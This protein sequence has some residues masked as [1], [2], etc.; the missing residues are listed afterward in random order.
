[1]SIESCF[2]WAIKITTLF[3]GQ[4]QKVAIKG[5]RPIHTYGQVLQ[6]LLEDIKCDIYFFSIKMIATTID[7]K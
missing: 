5:K 6:C 2:L 1:M 4:Y 7:D 3:L